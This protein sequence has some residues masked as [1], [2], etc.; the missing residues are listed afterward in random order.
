MADPIKNIV[1]N[2]DVAGLHRRMNRFIG[3]MAAS[4][5][6]NL[7]QMSEYDQNRLR[8]YLG[9]V[10]TYVNWVI[11]QP[12]L[13]LPETSPRKYELEANPVVP[14][15]ENEAIIDIIR[16]MELARDEVTDGQ[17]ARMSSGLISF[18][19]QRVGSVINKIEAFLDSYV[20]IITPLDLPESSPTRP[21]TAAGKTGV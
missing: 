15:V 3:E 11:S 20:A 1:Y 19:V 2:H 6:T 4:A 9:A 10:R 12:Q 16:M 18:D 21:V 8:T 13:D 5:S 7:S 17:S 14:L